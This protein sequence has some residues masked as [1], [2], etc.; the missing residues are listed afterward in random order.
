MTPQRYVVIGLARVRAPWFA[1]VARWAHA[2]SVPI[3]FV[4]CISPAEAHARLE[5]GRRVSALIL[6]AGAPGI[7]RDL[8]DQARRLGIASIII[9]DPRV[10]KDWLA[11]GATEV[12]DAHFERADLIAALAQHASPV[13]SVDAPSAAGLIESEPDEPSL[14]QGRHIAVCGSSGSGTSTLAMGLA[15]ELAA[16]PLNRGSVLLADLSLRADLAM[17]HDTGD[18]VPGLQELV[19]AHQGGRP[20]ASTIRRMLYDIDTR[21]YLLLLGLRR[22][23]DWT[24]LRPRALE[25]ALESLASGFRFVITDIDTDFD[26]EEATGSI[27]VEDRNAASRCAA[28]RAEVCVVVSTPTLVGIH[29]AMRITSD[30]VELGVEPKRILQVINRAPRAPRARSEIVQV[31]AELAGPVLETPP[32]VFLAERR[33]LEAIHRGGGALPSGFAG[34]L[35]RAVMAM[36]DHDPGLSLDV[37]A[38]SSDGDPTRHAARR[39]SA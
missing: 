23:R 26:G 18:V 32:V 15:Q 17:Y 13:P 29:S 24:A 11:L 12:L 14:W 35:A 39:R 8:I 7:D 34:A 10:D 3:E 1:E 33:G 31:L 25:T 30:L 19:E 27:D 38:P 36:S 6:D 2:A 9:D 16:I 20:T 22:S 37:V 28:R 21:G 5:A 4:K